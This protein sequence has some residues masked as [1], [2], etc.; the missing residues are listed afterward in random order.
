MWRQEL[1]VV[2]MAGNEQKYFFI[3]SA[4]NLLPVHLNCRPNSE[5][6]LVTVPAQSQ[7]FLFDLWLCRSPEPIVLVALCCTA[8]AA[9]F[10]AL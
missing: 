3:A 5:V 6:P 7:Y 4:K 8:V 9:R 2:G 1:N 10:S